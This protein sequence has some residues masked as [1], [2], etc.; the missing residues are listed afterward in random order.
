MTLLA[1]LK[2]GLQDS[3]I[4]LLMAL[5]TSLVIGALFFLL[6]VIVDWLTQNLLLG[7]PVAVEGAVL[8]MIC[9]AGYS[10]IETGRQITLHRLKMKLTLNIQ[11][12]LY[13][14]LMGLPL[15][16]YRSQD[17]RFLAQDVYHLNH[18]LVAFL[19]QLI[20]KTAQLLPL[21]IAFFWWMPVMLLVF[22]GG[23]IVIWLLLYLQTRHRLEAERNF[24]NLTYQIIQGIAKLRVLGAVETIF[25]V[26]DRNLQ[27]FDRMRDDQKM[28]I[29]VLSFVPVLLMFGVLDKGV[30]TALG[31]WFYLTHLA[32]LLI[33]ITNFIP[34]LSRYFEME[35][36][37]SAELPS[38]S[39]PS[40]LLTGMIEVRNVTY[41]YRADPILKGV[42]L[43]IEAGQHVAIVGMSGAGKSTLLKILA[44]L[45]RPESGSVFYDGYDLCA[46][47]GFERQIGMVLQDSKIAVG[48]IWSNIN[49]FTRYPI[50]AAWKAA[51]LANIDE[52]IASLAM[53]MHTLV[54]EH[55]SIL[56]RGQAQRLLIA[57]ALVHQPRILFFD[58]ATSALDDETQAIIFNN[59]RQYTV[60]FVAHRLST[61]QLAD[62]IYLLQDGVVAEHGAYSELMAQSS[63]F[64]NLIERQLI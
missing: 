50:E 7:N 59:L 38:A 43:H 57:R 12:V 46:L 63:V 48:S 36:V 14:H 21:L 10:F 61:M 58:D 25:R 62:K 31:V 27:Q 30:G 33:L 29:T 51:K 6:A 1:L 16:V 4:G 49:S 42:S 26:W 18:V 23:M 37:L 3:R 15:S 34:T 32:Q 19:L 5:V 47:T 41:S 56:S 8:L 11:S 54:D 22:W 45:E 20:C 9:V 39:T 64:T 40:P 13:Q 24:Y 2:S 60:I 53:N 44:G 35:T 52:V 28:I 17:T 55:A